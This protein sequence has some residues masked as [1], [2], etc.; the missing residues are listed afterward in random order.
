MHPF[1]VSTML[2]AWVLVNGSILVYVGAPNQTPDNLGIEL[3]NGAVPQGPGTGLAELKDHIPRDSSL[4]KA[5]RHHVLCV[6]PPTATESALF[7]RLPQLQ[8]GKDH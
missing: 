1:S 3:T 4:G 2:M 7:K 5:V 6:T 8:Q